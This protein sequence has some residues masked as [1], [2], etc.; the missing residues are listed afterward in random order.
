MELTESFSIGETCMRI[1]VV[2]GICEMYV[3]RINNTGGTDQKRYTLSLS[4]GTVS[5]NLKFI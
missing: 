4:E 2:N 1:K 3:F 5:A